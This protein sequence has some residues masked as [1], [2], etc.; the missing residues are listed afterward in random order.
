MMRIHSWTTNLMMT[1]VKIHF[2][3]LAAAP[4]ATVTTPPLKRR[5][6]QTKSKDYSIKNCEGV[7]GMS[8]PSS[9]YFVL[10]T[11]SLENLQPGMH[12]LENLQSDMICLENLQPGM[13]CLENLC[14]NMV[15]TCENGDIFGQPL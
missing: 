11:S 5:K 13:L 2:R 1:T 4:T 15:C 9:V 6:T 3:K 12:C 14:L 10:R 7:M 8:K